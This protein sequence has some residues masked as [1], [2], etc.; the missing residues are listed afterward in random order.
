M[1]IYGEIIRHLGKFGIKLYCNFDKLKNLYKNKN[2]LITGHT[3]FNRSWLVEFLNHLNANILGISNYKI[4]NHSKSGFGLKNLN[5]EIISD[6]ND[7][8]NYS[9]Q[10]KKFNPEIVF[11]LAA[12]PIVR[13]AFKDPV[14][15]FES[16]VLG[17]IKFLNFIKSFDNQINT[18]L[19]ITS[20][21]VYE[22]FGN[23]KYFEETDKLGGLEPYS[24]SK[25]MQEIISKC[26]FESYFKGKTRLV[27]ARA[28]NVL[29]G[30]DWC[31]DRLIVDI[32]KSVMS[33]KT[34]DVRYPNNTRPWQ[35]I[36]DLIAGYL[37]LI[38]KVSKEEKK[39]FDTFNFAPEQSFPSMK[40]I[41]FAKN[42]W[43][44][45]FNF[46]LSKN[47]KHIFEEPKLSMSSK[48]IYNYLGWQTNN[49]LS[50]ILEKTFSWYNSYLKNQNMVQL[51]QSM[52]EEFFS[53]K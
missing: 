2:V 51:N 13:Q 4:K 21:K 32:M 45:K 18:I 20:D 10:I 33:K 26:Y 43:G 15:T 9:N 30:G 47:K 52:I 28:G 40:I 31:T 29:G 48:K 19:I 23:K 53:S 16:N 35:Y 49:D 46:K 42:Y 7:V 3:D 8:K 12:Q 44:D 36:L 37:G 50:S 38:L 11:Y 34:M 39:F 6:I 22:S 1:K 14:Y 27:T 5:H 41:E 17:L 24:A 25:A